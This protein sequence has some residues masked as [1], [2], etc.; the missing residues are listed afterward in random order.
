M[1]MSISHALS[2]P[3]LSTPRALLF[4]SLALNLFFVGLTAALLV[5]GPAAATPRN[6]AMRIESLAQS[7]PAADGTMLRDNFT[8]Q[9]AAIEAARANYDA[10]RDRIREVL[11]RE[12][13]DASAMADTMSKARAARQGYDQALQAMLAKAAAEMSP[14]GRK[15]MA[16]WPPS[17]RQRS[18]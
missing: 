9:R 17:S 6:V 4:G 5:R 2:L 14:A 8:T 7:L 12:P 1:T 11:R 10:S 13:F 3:S 16:D 15:A 18:Q